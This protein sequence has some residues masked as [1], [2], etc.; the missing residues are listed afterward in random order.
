MGS[1]VLGQEAPLST[2]GVSS[3]VLKGLP[4]LM[5]PRSP[6]LESLS[7]VLPTTALPPLAVVLGT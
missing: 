6:R 5:C 2:Q 4:A 7:Q 3:D 1:A